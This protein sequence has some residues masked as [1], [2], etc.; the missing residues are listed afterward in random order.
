MKL[1]AQAARAVLSQPLEHHPARRPNAILEIPQLLRQHEVEQ[2]SV[3][4]NG[5]RGIALRDAPRRSGVAQTVRGG[6]RQRAGAQGE[7]ARDA[8]QR[9]QSAPL[10]VDAP[11]DDANVERLAGLLREMSEETQFLLI[12]HNRRTMAHVDVLY[13][14]TMEEPGVSRIVSVRLEE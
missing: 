6:S 5:R 10:Q 4:D 11:L 13:G 12:T 2:L 7:R 9:H 14:V 1:D 3:H 8:Y